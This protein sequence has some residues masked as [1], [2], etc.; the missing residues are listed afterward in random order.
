VDF[1]LKQNIPAVAGL[2]NY[3]FNPCFGGFFS[4]TSRVVASQGVA[5]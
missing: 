1:S 2:A 3:G 5:S 4:K